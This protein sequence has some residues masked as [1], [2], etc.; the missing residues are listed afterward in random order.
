LT[1]EAVVAAGL[2]IGDAEGLEAV[3]LRRI[4]GDVGVTPM[5]L[6]RYV[7][8]K[9]ELLDAMLDAVWGEVVLPDPA[10]GE[11]WEGLATVG[12]S[13]RAAFLAHPA[14]AAIAATRPRGGQNV[15]RVI[16]AILALLERAG[17]GPEQAA[18]IYLPFARALLS[19][20]VFEASLLPELSQGDR[21]QQALRTRF[22]LESLPADEFPYVIAAAP[23]LA[24][25]YEPERVF[26]E[27]LELLHAGIEAQLSTP[28]R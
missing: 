18:R 11:W 13:T 12:R 16:E 7:G 6:Y 27:G 8:S 15:V 21:R 2:A 1:R 5:A 17:F 20:I 19:L 4:A 9:E 10:V 22:E 25:P 3:S 26:E 23:H 28:T 24:M 14:A